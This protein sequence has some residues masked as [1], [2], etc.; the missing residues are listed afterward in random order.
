MKRKLKI[1]NTA[2]LS[3]LSL[4]LLGSCNTAVEDNTISE[5]H[6]E[7]R[8][9]LKNFTFY[10]EAGPDGIIANLDD[11]E[12]NSTD[13]I[14]YIG[15]Y[16]GSETEITVPATIRG[17]V[18]QVVGIKQNAFRGLDSEGKETG[19][20]KLTK[21][22]LPDSIETIETRSFTNLKSLTSMNIPEH[23]IIGTNAFEGSSYLLNTYVE[24]DTQGLMVA[25]KNSLYG[26]TANLSTEITLPEQIDT[27]PN[28]FFEAKKLTK[29]NLNKNLLSIG[30]NA[31][32]NNQL[33]EVTIPNS[34]TS[35]GT[36]AF[37]NNKTLTK[38]YGYDKASLTSTYSPITY[39][40]GTNV[41]IL[42]GSTENLS[43]VSYS[44]EVTL[45]KLLGAANADAV[46]VNKVNM[47]AAIIVKDALKG[48][49]SVTDVSLEPTVKVVHSGAL[50]NLTN[51]TNFYP[52]TKVDGHQLGYIEK[53]LDKDGNLVE[54]SFF[55]SDYYKKVKEGL[56]DNS[57]VIF[58]G[59][60][61]D[62]KGSPDINSLK[63][64]SLKGIGDSIL[65]GKTEVNDEFLNSIIDAENF[66]SLGNKALRGTSITQIDMKKNGAYVGDLALADIT[67]LTKATFND[68]IVLSYGSTIGSLLNSTNLEYLEG[69]VTGTYAEL[70]GSKDIKLKELVVSEGVTEIARTAFKGVSTL[71]KVTLPKES[72][73]AI[74]EDSF[75]KTAISSIY[76]PYSV[77]TIDRA[78]FRD[79]KSLKD[80]EFQDA[81][82][83]GE[84]AEQYNR[85]DSI[86]INGKINRIDIQ[87]LA[88]AG[89]TSLEKVTIPFRIRNLYSA[90]LECSNLKSM[91]IRLT[92]AD[93]RYNNDLA[94]FD[95][96]G[97]TSATLTFEG[98]AYIGITIPEGQKNPEQVPFTVV[99]L[100]M[101]FTK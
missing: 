39:G 8:E 52:N 51:L 19:A 78:A 91:E 56:A 73:T 13:D 98:F 90:F 86:D 84:G 15:S 7:F 17:G 69:P 92:D 12:L 67:T 83:Y 89:C 63:G 32:N 74:R 87:S 94:T 75:T 50:D 64:L 55:A 53:T 68:S 43:E 80:I 61:I 25:N 11:E 31:F 42:T 57:Y 27:I 62:T 49:D 77:T 93:R 100:G 97:D 66:N 18:F 20:S 99:G 37:G 41:A 72:L 71:E 96:I 95:P 85:D 58:G 6:Q 2:L 10:Q 70:V 4:S 76:I 35:I 21:I 45:T 47:N 3:L 14:I 82:V 24:T 34:V 26:T 81:K 9:L 46:K 33:V 88:F 38:F 23:T 65:E 54:N 28:N 101:S 44:G 22:T 40:T 79:C 59:G 29:I 5:E 60:V 16:I 30:S 1:F 48:L 36:N